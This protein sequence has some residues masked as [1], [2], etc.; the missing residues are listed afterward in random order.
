MPVRYFVAFLIC[1]VFSYWL[2]YHWAEK[3]PVF[4]RKNKKSL[5]RTIV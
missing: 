3:K 1:T 4:K 5:R 2:V